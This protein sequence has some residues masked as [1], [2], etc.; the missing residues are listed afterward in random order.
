[1]TGFLAG[2]QHP[3]FERD[4]GV[5]VYTAWRP[6]GGRPHH[7]WRCLWHR[8]RKHH[9]HPQRYPHQT[10]FFIGH[11][12]STKLKNKAQSIKHQKQSC[13]KFKKFN[14]SS[15]HDVEHSGQFKFSI[16]WTKTEH[17]L[18][19]VLTRKK[20][21]S[22]SFLQGGTP[23]SLNWLWTQFKKVQWWVEQQFKFSFWPMNWTWIDHQVQGKNWIELRTSIQFWT[24]IQLWFKFN[25]IGYTET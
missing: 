6:E 23:L 22:S 7:W 19:C 16:N 13:V 25:H 4:Q 15:V 14:S 2:Y 3:L 12:F 20:P 9:G 24:A 11:V 5:G 8:P 1:M 18:L 17:E 21:S 10:L